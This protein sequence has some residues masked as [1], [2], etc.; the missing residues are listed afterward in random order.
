M[1]AS[2]VMKL[3]HALQNVNFLGIDTSPFIYFVEQNPLYVD[4][5][6]EVFKRLTAKDF[7]ASSSV[8]TL[9]EVL[10]QPL[11]QQNQ[12][13]ADAYRDLLFNGANFKLFSITAL[14]AE[15]AAELCARY[16]LRTPDALQI[17]TALENGCD[18]FLCNDNGL[19][20]VGELRILV[21]DE[22]EL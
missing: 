3:E 1:G 17:A 21:L 7:A 10:V 19:K 6:R 15:R 5:L 16:N 13:L 22:L 14:I 2:P 20:R 8:V 12:T 4:L 11:R 18:A 9:T